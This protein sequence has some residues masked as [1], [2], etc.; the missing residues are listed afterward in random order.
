MKTK[1]DFKTKFAEG[2]SFE[3]L[4][5]IFLIG[6]F[7][8][9]IYE[10]SYGYI[11]MWIIHEQPRWIIHRG[12]IYGSLNIIY[13]VGAVI[14]TII[15]VTKKRPKWK[16]FLYASLLGGLTEY[17]ISYIQEKCLGTISWDYSNKFLNINGRTTIIYM[18]FWGILGVIFVNHIYPILSKWIEKIPIRYGKIFTNILVILVILDMLISF[19]ALYRQKQRRQNI[20]PQNK[21]EQLYDIYYTDEFLHKYYDNMVP[22]EN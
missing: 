6:S 19:T 11:R 18:L 10:S 2:K 14:M 7:F 20:P 15:L 9:A 21:I 8:G 13:G 3:K 16:T 1:F 5:F 22:I 17:T 4:F 12:V